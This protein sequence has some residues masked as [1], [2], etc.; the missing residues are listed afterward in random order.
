MQKFVIDT[1]ALLKFLN[2]VRVISSRIEQI[3]RK[4]GISS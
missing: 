1:Q 4:A 2:G 3:L